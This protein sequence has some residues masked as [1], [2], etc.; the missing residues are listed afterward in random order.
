MKSFSKMNRY[1]GSAVSKI[2]AAVKRMKQLSDMREVHF[3]RKVLSED[4]IEYG[5]S[6]ILGSSLIDRSC[7]QYDCQRHFQ[8]N[9]YKALSTIAAVPY[10]FFF[11][12]QVLKNRGCVYHSMTSPANFIVYAGSSS[13]DGIVPEALKNKGDYISAGNINET[14]FDHDLY[15]YLKDVFR[16]SGVHPYFLVIAIRYLAKINHIIKH[17][18]PKTI[19]T[20]SEASFASSLITD[21]CHKFNVS[22]CGVM[23]GE[24]LIQS[25]TMYFCFDEFYV[26]DSYYITIFNKL[27][28][29]VPEYHVAVPW[30]DEAF[31]CSESASG[32][33]TYYLQDTPRVK[34]NKVRVALERLEQLGFSVKVRMHPLESN[35]QEVISIF[36]SS[37]VE[38]ASAISIYESLRSCQ[39]AVSEYSTVLFQAHTFGRVPVV[40]DLSEEGSIQFLKDRAYIMLNKDHLLLSELLKRDVK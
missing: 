2:K 18:N 31:R 25:E 22:H 9:R 40:D 36:G 15:C 14:L 20:T 24:R 27:R 3:G 4:I 30:Q 34:L 13:N 19:I 26:W 35:K 29:Y 37:R 32:R 21:Y 8:S 12:A 23:H 10:L 11:C 1:T 38:P 5:N 39:Y 33:V 28:A 16:K 6:R 17:Y 7:V